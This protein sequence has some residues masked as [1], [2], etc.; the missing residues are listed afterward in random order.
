MRTWWLVLLGACGASSHTTTTAPPALPALLVTAPSGDG[1]KPFVSIDDP[2]VVLQHLHV[3][4]GTGKPGRD[5][6]TIVIDHGKVAAVGTNVATPPGAKVIDLTGRSAFPGLVDMHAHMFYGQLTKPPIEE[7][8]FAEQ[9]VS[10]PR[11][12]LAAGVT[13]ARTTGTMEPYADLT[14]KQRIDAGQ[15]PG[16]HL[17]L[18]APYLEGA[19]TPFFQM[20]RLGSAEQAK[21]FVEF[22]IAS[23]FTSIKAY[24]NVTRAELGAAIEAAHARGV[25]VTGHL[26]SVGFREAAELGID[27]LEHGY[28]E[29]SEVD[30]GKKPDVCPEPGKKPP[31]DSPQV[32][33]IIDVLVKKRVAVTSTLA[34]I[35][36]MSRAGKTPLDPRA[37]AVLN[38]TTRENV[39][40][41]HAVLAK[42]ENDDLDLE[43]K[44]ERAFVKAG[45]LLLAGADPSG[46]G[47]TVAG[48]GDQRQLEL[49]VEAGFTAAEAI[50]IASDHGAKFLGVESEIGTIATGKRADLVIVKGNPEVRIAD[51][52]NVEVVFKDGVGYD[53]T[54]LIDSV[55]GTVGL[56]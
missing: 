44:F 11:L 26:C 15:M 53:P 42:R 3:I 21:Q 50:Q 39:E 25:K 20:A 31:V 9:A 49:L 28:V 12:Y 6:L 1:T 36:G 2:V 30:A 19:G 56:H 24:N 18:T 43:M 37:M 55:K 51:V 17:Q 38:P 48:F 46:Y 14:M 45:G 7:V 33:A 4:D 34:V 29:D 5:D 54:K 8:V 13:T 22:W 41:I 52:E 23:G 47:A 16:P 40:R 35:E 27:N 10:F 32:Q